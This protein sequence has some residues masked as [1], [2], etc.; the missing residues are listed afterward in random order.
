MYN[1]PDFAA[2][3]RKMERFSRKGCYLAIRLP[4]ASGVMAELSLKIYG[5]QHDSVNAVVAY[6]ALHT[7]G[8]YANVLVEKHMVNWVNRTRE[9]AFDRAKRHLCLDVAETAHD[10]LIH[11]A[12]NRRLSLSDGVY[13]WPDG[14][15]TA[16]LWWSPD[17]KED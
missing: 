3:V 10:D 1:S 5:C 9:D 11:S 6:N 13:V 7:M 8:I 15:R 12:L 2:F 14:M 16:L 4:P 17:H